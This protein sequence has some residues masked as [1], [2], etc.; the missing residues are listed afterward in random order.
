M[1]SSFR[2][3]H[4][5]GKY[6][7][8]SICACFTA[9]YAEHCVTDVTAGTVSVVVVVVVGERASVVVSDDGAHVRRS[10]ELAA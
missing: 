4:D 9:A 5:F 10:Y 1:G 7:T 6:C 2:Q 3:L 8:F